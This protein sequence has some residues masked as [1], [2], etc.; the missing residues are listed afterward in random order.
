MK[1]SKLVVAGIFACTLLTGAASAQ[2]GMQFFKKPN[3][4]DIFNPV[5]GNGA[6]Y[7]SSHGDSKRTMEMSI[8]GREAV[9]TQDGYWMEVTNNDDARAGGPTYAKILITKDDFQFHKMIMQM[10]GKPPIELPMGMNGKANERR[11]EEI[12]KMKLVGSES[13][14]V[15]AGTFKC[16]HYTN[17][18]GTENVWVN[19]S[20]SPMGLVKEVGPDNSMI[21]VKTITGATDKITGTPQKFDPQMM[22]QQMM[23]KQQQKP[24]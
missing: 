16:D 3:I 1:R 4:A 11:N 5:V 7:E 21:L 19:K 24:N 14:T 9:G 13:I 8:V 22:R 15:P 12:S 17:E 10:P 6:V 2:M 20:I 23:Q 18:D